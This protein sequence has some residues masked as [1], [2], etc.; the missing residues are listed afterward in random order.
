M[1]LGGEVHKWASKGLV[2]TYKTS[3]F[4]CRQ[5]VERRAQRSL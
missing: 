1:Q 4:S 5:Q 2:G 3:S